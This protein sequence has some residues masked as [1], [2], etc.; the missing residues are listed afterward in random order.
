MTTISTGTS[1]ISPEL[2]QK[3]NEFVN[4]AFWGTLLREFREASEPTVL[5]S[6]PGS[7][8]FTQLLD[9]E[10]VKRMSERGESPLA[11]A[12]LKQ[13]GG[14]RYRVGDMKLPAPL[15]NAVQTMGL[16]GNENV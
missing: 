9:M 11:D 10:M 1:Q 3:T 14:S 16:R 13:L 4:M 6:G 2:R 7:G 12:L 5:D 8:P 15:P